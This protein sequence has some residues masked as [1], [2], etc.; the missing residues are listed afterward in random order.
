MVRRFV[1]TTPIPNV[2]E[3]TIR[4]HARAKRFARLERAVQIR[5]LLLLAPAVAFLL[6]FY[7]YP[8]A[9]MLARAFN[10]PV[11]GFQNFER[12][13]AVTRHEEVLGLFSI[14]SNAYVR[15]FLI[16]LRISA[17]VTLFTLLLGY[18]VAYVLSAIRPSRANILMIFVLVPFWTSILVRSYAWMVLLGREGTVNELMIRIGL[19]DTPMQLLNTRLAVYVGMVHI[20]LPFMILPLYSVMRGIDR[21]Y[22]RAAENLG[23]KPFQTFRHIFLPLTLPGIAAGALVVFILSLGFYITP[24]LIGGPRDVM[25]SMLIAQQVNTLNWGFGSALALVLLVMAVAIY[26]LF[27]K[28]LGVNRL[29]GG[30]R[31]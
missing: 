29:Y 12:L 16:T 27:N 18:P 2:K 23:A 20:L 28:I 15:V 9:A 22:L 10:D 6:F 17:I 7:G 5:Y 11:W 19:R 25:I 30:A 14:P 3:E 8:V 1:A 13:R 31:A 24:A 26:L 21:N 4:P